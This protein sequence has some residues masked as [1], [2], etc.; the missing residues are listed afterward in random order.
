MD[1]CTALLRLRIVLPVCSRALWHLFYDTGFKENVFCFSFSQLKVKDSSIIW[2]TDTA[3]TEHTQFTLVKEN[4]RR[5]TFLLSFTHSVHHRRPV[6]GQVVKD[7]AVGE[8]RQFGVK[9][10][11][12]FLPVTVNSWVLVLLSPFI[13][14]FLFNL[15]FFITAFIFFQLRKKTEGFTLQTTKKVQKQMSEWH[16]FIF[17]WPQGCEWGHKADCGSVFWMLPVI[18]LIGLFACLH[19]V[20]S[21]K[22]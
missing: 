12:T 9:R 2:L 21:H 5:R 6:V 11:F 20:V 10:V 14:L 18:L 7:T 8:H 4:N 13:L 16:W 19:Q 3:L 15:T 1:H 17:L 22:N